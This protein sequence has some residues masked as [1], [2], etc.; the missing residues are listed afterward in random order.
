[1][2]WEGNNNIYCRISPLTIGYLFYSQISPFTIIIPNECLSVLLSSQLNGPEHPYT[3][4]AMKTLAWLKVKLEK[5]GEAE[6]LYRRTQVLYTTVYGEHHQ[7]WLNISLPFADLLYNLDHD[8]SGPA[9]EAVKN[10]YQQILSL[11]IALHGNSDLSEGCFETMSRLGYILAS[12]KD[13]SGIVFPH[14]QFLTYCGYFHVYSLPF[15]TLFS[16]VS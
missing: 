14:T 6:D 12:L 13:L 15:V 9:V 10:M 3:L 5:F 4:N 1:M 7:E 16:L 8:S 2:V 11:Q